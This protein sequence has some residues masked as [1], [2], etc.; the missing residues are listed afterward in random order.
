MNE[1]KQKEREKEKG[2]RKKSITALDWL[3]L[4]K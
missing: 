3:G 4:D 2:T 1:R